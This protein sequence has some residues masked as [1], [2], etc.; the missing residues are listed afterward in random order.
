M[1]FNCTDDLK[2]M[3]AQYIRK[4]QDEKLTYIYVT[5][6]CEYKTDRAC[7]AN[8]DWHFVHYHKA[9]TDAMCAKLGCKIGDAH[10]MNRSGI[11][12]LIVGRC[13]E[14]HAVNDLLQEV[15]PDENTAFDVTDLVFSP[16]IRLKG[17]QMQE[18]DVMEPCVNCNTLFTK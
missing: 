18:E 8:G 3:H 14:Q 4:I 17:K 2:I 1:N 16:A 6:A 15:S 7:G 9:L 11:R 10:G 5:S 12:P 13:A